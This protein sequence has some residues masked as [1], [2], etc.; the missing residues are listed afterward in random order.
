MGLDKIDMFKK[1]KGWT[2]EDLANASG[3]PKTTIDKIT[4]GQTKDPKLETI[5]ALVHSLGRTLNDLDDKH[6]GA[7]ALSFQVRDH[8]KKYNALDTHGTQ[9]VDALLDAEYDRVCQEKKK[10]VLR[11]SKILKFPDTTPCRASTQTASAG[12]GTYLGP[13]EF[14]TINVLSEH[15]PRNISFCVPVSGDSMEPYYYDGDMLIVSTEKDLRIGDIGI[16]TLDNE[17]YVKKLGK[18]E[19][20][21]L[22]P[23]YPP[24]RMNESI[25]CNGKVIGV[26]DPDWIVD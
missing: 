14:E 7:E 21:S 4:S 24:I 26:L 25:V 8:I 10:S 20:I 1:E 6:D 13:E 2:N 9:V 12:T 16:F 15:V 17:G 19:L 18:G 3:V 11:D 5:K 22:N 23:A